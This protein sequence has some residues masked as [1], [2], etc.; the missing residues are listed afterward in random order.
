MKDHR[1]MEDRDIHVAAAQ[2]RLKD[3]QK[4]IQQNKRQREARG[5]FGLR[6]LH[7]AARSGS[8]EC[9]EYLIKCGADVN[10][11][12]MEHRSTPLFYAATGGIAKLLI[13]KGAEVNAVTK[14]R[15]IPLD[16]AVQSLNEEVVDV[17][18][19]NHADVNYQSKTECFHTMLQWALSPETTKGYN[20]LLA[21]RIIVKL[22]D[23]G[24]D[25]DAVNI[26]NT[27]AL[28]TACEY[29]LTS[30]VKVLLSRGADPNKYDSYHKTA[31]DAAGDKPEIL[32]LLLPYKKDISLPVKPPRVR[33]SPEELMKRL[34]S[35]GKVWK[36]NL[37]RCSEADLDEL[38]R[39]HGVSL[40]ASY[41][42]FLIHMGRGAGV[43]LA[44]GWEIFYDDLSKL[45]TKTDFSNKSRFPK[46]APLE[47][48]PNAFVFARNNDN[49]HLYFLLDGTEED[50]PVYGFDENGDKGL[51]YDSFWD[52]FEDML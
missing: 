4:I 36:W 23:A 8:L 6:P 45:G 30:I 3:L 21:E 33:E 11:R 18:I 39:T 9:V 50:P 44:N 32:D 19:A 20:R 16:F 51:L 25:P 7:Y 37:K 47:L 28:H 24:A 22:L 34:V 15:R 17:L 35:G 52:F 5:W 43:F 13:A 38:E 1:G 48:A 27:S 12:C 42:M 29:G 26:F 40:P 14:Q 10:A 49:Q 2:G 46:G 31:F 41:I